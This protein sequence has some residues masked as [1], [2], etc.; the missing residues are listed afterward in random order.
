MV[1]LLKKKTKKI[2]ENLSLKEYY[3]IRNKILFK[4]NGGLG[5]LLMLRMMF[6]DLKSLIPDSE[7]IVSCSENFKDAIIDHP[8]IDKIVY[9]HQIDEEQYNIEYQV[10][11]PIVNF[12]ETNKAKTYTEHRSDLWASYCGVKL[13]SHDMCL[14]F[15]SNALEYCKKKIK[16]VYKNDKPNIILSPVSANNFKSLTASQIDTIAES[17]RDYNLIGLHNK[18]LKVLKSVYIPGIYTTNLRE[19]MGIVACAEYVISVD[20]ATFHLAGGLKKPLVGIF[21]FANGKVYGQHFD[22]VLIQ[23][24]RDNGD[25]SCGP[26]YDFSKCTKGNNQTKP[27]LTEISKEEIKNGIKMMFEKW[28]LF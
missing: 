20:T 24:H 3:Q 27:C 14:R 13:K 22:F 9:N 26:C 25:W 7:F 21:T 16:N 19:W 1:K 17:T 11:V 8:Y 23:K 4:H 2:K 5:D 12:Y 18:E 15:N 6:K 10:D 28:P